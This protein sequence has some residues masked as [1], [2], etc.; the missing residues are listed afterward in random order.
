MPGFKDTKPHDPQLLA[1][2][3]RPR[4]LRAIPSLVVLTTAM[5]WAASASAGGLEFDGTSRGGA[6]TRGRAGSVQGVQAEALA[7]LNASAKAR[8]TGKSGMEGA[9]D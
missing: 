8:S 6:E 4:F 7:G 9:G 5:A 1:R 2:I 3:A